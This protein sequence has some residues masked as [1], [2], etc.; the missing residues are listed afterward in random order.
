MIRRSLIS[1]VVANLLLFHSAAWAT[2]ADDMRSLLEQNKAQ[3]AYQLG[4]A[5]PD[6]LGDPA[7][8]FFYG[9]AAI[10]A[11]HPGEGVLALERYILIFPDNGDAR[12]QLA[13]G[14]FILGEDQRARDEFETLLP[15][16]TG[17]QK[18]AIE[19][20]LDAIRARESRYQP[21]AKAYVEAGLGVD[22]NINAGLSAGATP[23]IPG[24]GTLPA[25]S[26]NSISAREK[27]TFVT[28]SA[29]V[30]GTYPV[31]P[32]IAMYGAGGVDARRHLGSNNNV[33][34]Q[35]SL[36]ATGGV[37]YL[38]EKNLYKAGAFLS[39][40]W[41]DNQSYVL[42][43]GLNG[44]WNH[45]LD[46]FNRLTLGAQL[47]RYNYDNMNIFL[48]KDKAGG[49]VLSVLTDRNSDFIGI[50]GAWAH[51][52]A[53]PYQPVVTVS[54]NYGEERN[55]R[56]RADLSRDIYGARASFAMTPA[57]RWGVGAGIGYQENKYRDIFTT[58]SVNRHDTSWSLDGALSYFYT[59]QF[60]IRAEAQIFDQSSNIGLFKYSREVV[61]VK[62]RYEF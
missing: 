57:E 34:D 48:T 15:N 62:A 42:T 39:Q 5:S 23:Q 41:V 19:R 49:P 8:D 47:A 53:M 1:A 58:G 46:Q 14:Y 18:I 2:P 61:A 54:A 4:R 32:G 44:E 59:K 21:T 31:S 56:N 6:L 11:G 51:A 16:S 55:Q 52:F 33:F 30:Q 26:S 36:G 27:D 40:S 50:S 29:G 43:Y 35:R 10:D 12:F 45:Q 3:D 38:K 20:Y 13:R 9:I 17:N 7:F 24:L 25:I 60:S 37:S 22:T 28:A